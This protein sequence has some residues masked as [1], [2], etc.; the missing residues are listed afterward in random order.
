MAW[1]NP[2]IADIVAHLPGVRGAIRDKANEG[3]GRARAVLAAHRYEG[4]SEITVTRGDL[5]D[6]FVNLDDSRGEH[7]AAAIEYGRAAVAGRGGPTQGVHA[8]GAAF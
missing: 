8:L 5:L 7:A 4:H 1:V 6:Y 2:N 3:A